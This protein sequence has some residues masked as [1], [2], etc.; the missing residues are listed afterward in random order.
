MSE[1]RNLDRWRAVFALINYPFQQSLKKIFAVMVA[2]QKPR[3]PNP[4]SRPRLIF[5]HD[6][7]MLGERVLGSARLSGHCANSPGPWAQPET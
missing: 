1:S 6:K 3:Q 4:F 5:E 2:P 7:R